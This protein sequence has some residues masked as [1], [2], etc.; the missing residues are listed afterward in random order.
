MADSS[1]IC[2]CD[3]CGA[4]AEFSTYRTLYVDTECEQ[5]N[6]Y[7]ECGACHKQ[8]TKDLILEVKNNVE[9]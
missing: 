5:T 9:Q 2:L 7:F 6:R 1:S 4:P 8:A 3:W